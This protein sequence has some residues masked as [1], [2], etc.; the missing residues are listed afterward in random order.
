M[1][2]SRAGPGDGTRPASYDVQSTTYVVHVYVR[3][4]RMCNGEQKNEASME[5]KEDKQKYGVRTLYLAP[6][7]SIPT[8]GRSILASPFLLGP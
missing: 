1:A 7:V 6:S 4:L 3:A 8:R 2:H 5:G